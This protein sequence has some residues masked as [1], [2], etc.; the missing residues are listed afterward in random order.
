MHDAR[1]PPHAWKK[2]Y[3][4]GIHWD[5]PIATSA[6]Q[7][8]LDRAVADYGERP[9]LEYRDQRLSYRELGN[10]AARAAAA[11]RH[12]GIGRGCA[13]AL[14]LPN[15]A[16]HPIAFFGVLRTGAHV[17]HL[18]PLDAERELIHKLTDSGARTLV[19]VNLFGLREKALRLAAAGHLDR[20]IVAD[21]GV[22]G[23]PSPSSS[24]AGSAIVFRH[25]P[26]EGAEALSPPQGPQTRAD[27]PPAELRYSEGS[28]T[29]KGD[30]SRQQPTSVG[31]GDRHPRAMV[32][33]PIGAELI[34]LEFLMAEAPTPSMWPPVSLDD[35]ALLQYTGGTTGVPMAA[36]L[37]HAN[38]TAAVSSYRIW[39]SGQRSADAPP[40]RVLMV[41]PLFHIYGL[42]SVMLRHLASGNELL[43]R[44]R[45]DIEAVLRDI[46][47]NR[48]TAFPGVPTMWAAVV[49]YPGIE[50]RDLS[51]LRTCG[52]G[53]APLP[54]ELA[55]R[56]GRITG[57]A[58][59]RGWGMT[60]TS[61]AG[62]NSPL[63]GPAKPGTV[64][65][66][67]PGITVEVVALDN[68]HRVL[69]PGEVGELRIKGKNVMQRYWNRPGETA[70]FADGGFLTGDIGTMDEDGYFFILD[71]KKD[72]I[73]SGGF[74][75]YPQLI[76]QAIYEHP[77]VEEVLVIGI[78]DPYRGE[79]AKAFVKLRPGA[80]PLTHGALKDFLADK[81]GRHE[82][83]AALEIRAALPRTGVGKLSKKELVQEERARIAFST[84]PAG[85]H[86]RQVE[87]GDAP[88]PGIC[89]TSAQILASPQAE[90]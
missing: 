35:I 82:M 8:L 63:H 22:W 45:F 58:L 83:P 79:A 59:R 7:E 12:I 77:D 80:P 85:P 20:V 32:D 64:G 84:P 70:A 73:L 71:R 50:Q 89:A 3:P 5:G 43:L 56:F 54:I 33:W 87:F 29:Q 37:T 78:P 88:S 67:L 53:G 61:A 81:V 2:S 75:V 49:N 90:E 31:G 16:W 52:S 48:V 86:A 9:A 74:N 62:I 17:V 40:D 68:P 42:V 57:L 19:T 60:E 25:P 30:R 38:L 51:A 69:V 10:Q 14:Y 26:L 24:V 39:I 47:V 15:T 36:V 46:E 66:P 65:L 4:A 72:M 23:P 18:S 21:E 44:S 13:V 41:L 11:F 76:E 27:P 1:R 28:A 6:L 34:S 55:E